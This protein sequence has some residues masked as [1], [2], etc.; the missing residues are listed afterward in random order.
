MKKSFLMGAVLIAAYITANAQNTVK[1]KF[2]SINQFGI[3]WGGTDD[4][5]QLQT[6]NGI[7]Y[8][9]WSAGIGLGL[10]YY[11]E[12]TVPIFLDLRKNVFS[13]K[14]TPFV[15]ADMGV[16]MPWVKAGKN[17]TWYS[18]DYSQG[19]Y[20]DIGIGYRVPVYKSLLANISFGYTQKKFRE[21]RKNEM[22]IFDFS[23]YG[24]N[25]VEHYS[26]TLR[27]LSLKLGLSF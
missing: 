11:W 13:K 7:T 23:P 24:H 17:D 3:A 19:G 22:N 15:Y 20:Y 8:Q 26:Y 10:D 2:T 1:P 25:S 4:A 18:S 9:T 27:R 12:R 6:I 21:E 5:L 14:Q 16:N